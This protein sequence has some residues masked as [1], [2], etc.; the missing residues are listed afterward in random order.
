MKIKVSCTGMAVITLYISDAY[1]CI[2]WLEWYIWYSIVWFVLW[3]TQGYPITLFK[4]FYFV[5]T[6]QSC[7]CP[8][9]IIGQTLLNLLM[10]E[11]PIKSVELLVW[12]KQTAFVLLCIAL[13]VVTTG[14][15]DPRL[16][17]CYVCGLILAQ[18][19]DDRHCTLVSIESEFITVC[20]L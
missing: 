4:C 16:I 15:Q 19:N 5:Q 9:A 12:E 2:Q 18:W 8:Y 13:Y 14:S 10:W 11:V 3:G 20:Y 1:I 17:S 7:Y 6:H